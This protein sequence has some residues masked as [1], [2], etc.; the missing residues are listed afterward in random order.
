MTITTKHRKYSPDMFARGFGGEMTAISCLFV[1]NMFFY[2]TH[3][4]NHV[5]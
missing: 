4:A 1:L 5:R 2:L 3:F